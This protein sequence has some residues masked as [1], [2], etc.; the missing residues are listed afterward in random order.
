MGWIQRYD[1]D[2]ETLPA[3]SQS[4]SNEDLGPLQT[5]VELDEIDHEGEVERD[6][7]ELYG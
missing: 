6:A 3:M 2:E 5:T 7:G 4:G 1:I